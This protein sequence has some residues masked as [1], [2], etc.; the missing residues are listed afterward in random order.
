M[1]KQK[2]EK[3][4]VSIGKASYQGERTLQEDSFYAAPMSAGK[5]WLG[6]VSDGM[7]GHQSGDVASQ[8]G[9]QSVKDE[10]ERHIHKGVSIKSALRISVEHAH[11]AVVSKAESLKQFGDMGATIVA[12][13]IDK[14]VVTWCA[15]G[16][17]RLY[18]VRDGSLTQLSRDF[19]LAT[20]L[21]QAVKG[22]HVTRQEVE[23]N[24]QRSAL[25]S[26]L[27]AEKLRTDEGAIRAL[28]G[29][30]F[31][32]CTDGIYGTTS[33]S[34][35][36]AACSDVNQSIANPAEKAVDIL[37]NEFLFPLKKPK[38]DNATVIIAS[39]Q[40]IDAHGNIVRNQNSGKGSRATLLR[41]GVVV[42]A[43]TVVTTAAIGLLMPTELRFL[44]KNEAAVK[45]VAQ[46]VSGPTTESPE[47][48]HPQKLERASPDR[49]ETSRN[50]KQGDND[51]KYFAERALL[52]EAKSQIERAQKGEA[53]LRAGLLDAAAQTLGSRVNS[54][55][56]DIRHEAS[57]SLSEVKKLQSEL[58]KPDG[59]IT[60]YSPRKAREPDAAKK[61][62]QD[63]TSPSDT[64]QGPA[65]PR[66]TENRVPIGSAN[67][68][69]DAETVRLERLLNGEPTYADQ[70]SVARQNA[71][72]P[73]ESVV[74][75]PLGV[76][77]PAVITEVPKPEKGLEKG[78]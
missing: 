25:T 55:Y 13:A 70:P 51:S 72:K 64:L 46:A 41:V 56:D 31:V 24:P 36:I 77:S 53:R 33:E 44:W 32:A 60:V 28:G 78:K 58:R 14:N 3:L 57:K 52:N 65:P 26:F 74:P 50:D 9:V 27:G 69:G 11:R 73:L 4:K 61:N 16:D 75:P 37:F 43:L 19:T 1:S 38:Q 30:F 71:A 45:P 62:A 23:A 7:G 5:P 8:I 10:F 54:S 42:G 22:G 63:V 15:A 2:A 76:S 6:V 67:N 12:F 35:L 29:D 17:S 21:E 49:P 68:S 34:G 20:D 59:N 47:V 39:I 40:E 18:L 48:K 66:A